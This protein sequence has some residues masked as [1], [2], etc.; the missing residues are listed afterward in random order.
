MMPV[1][2]LKCSDVLTMNK[3]NLPIAIA[4]KTHL[5]TPFMITDGTCACM[6]PHTNICE[7][8]SSLTH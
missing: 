4:S 2:Q 5:N 3:P 1:I 8:L 7:Y 6:Y